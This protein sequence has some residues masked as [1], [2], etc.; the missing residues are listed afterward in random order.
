MCIRGRGGSDTSTFHNC[1]GQW[2]VATGRSSTSAPIFPYAN[3]KHVAILTL[4]AFATET[5]H[6]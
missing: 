3:Q 6:S 5:P 4:S 1:R 2:A